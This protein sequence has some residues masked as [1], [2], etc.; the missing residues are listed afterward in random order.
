MSI[1]DLEATDF[2]YSPFLSLFAR[3]GTFRSLASR[4]SIFAN[5]GD[6]L[7]EIEVEAKE[8][9]FILRIRSVLKN[10]ELKNC[11]S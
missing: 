4:A 11:E 6:S 7:D 1:V 2:S 9:I 5:Y 8:I 3:V 10:V